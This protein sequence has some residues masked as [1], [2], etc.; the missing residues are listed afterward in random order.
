MTG[1]VAASLEAN[2][3]TPLF[4]VHQR[5]AMT[6]VD[7]A[8]ITLTIP[9]DPS[10]VRLVRLIVASCAAD[11]GYS[12]DRIE[13]IRIAADEAATLAIGVCRSDGLVRIGVSTVMGAVGVA[14]ECPTDVGAPEFDLLSSQIMTAL[15]TECTVTSVDEELR[16]FFNCPAF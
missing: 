9:A 11:A 3:T 5:T 2:G 14:M 15:T 8:T 6:R 1:F 10:F 7:E 13:D 12:F 16:V 4:P